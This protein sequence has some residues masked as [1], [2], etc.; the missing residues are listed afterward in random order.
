MQTKETTSTLTITNH[1]LCLMAEQSVFLTGEERYQV[2]RMVEALKEAFDDL[3]DILMKLVDAGFTFKVLGSG[4]YD[5]TS[6]E[7]KGKTFEHV[8]CLADIRGSRHFV[9]PFDDRKCS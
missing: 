8:K 3:V 7:N 1:S 9:N 2:E 6:V 4:M 5:L